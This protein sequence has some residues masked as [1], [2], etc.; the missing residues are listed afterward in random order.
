MYRWHY[1][2]KAVS[3]CSHQIFC[4]ASIYDIILMPEISKPSVHKSVYGGSSMQ[5]MHALILHLMRMAQSS[6]PI[7][8]GTVLQMDFWNVVLPSLTGVCW[9]WIECWYGLFNQ[10]P[11]IVKRLSFVLQ[12]QL[13][14][15]SFSWSWSCVCF[16]WA[17][18][19]HP[20]CTSNCTIWVTTELA[21]KLEYWL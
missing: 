1:S 7:R 18:I 4:V 20:S 3:I 5:P 12:I 16:K 13:C 19:T 15:A 2:C 10:Q 6:L 9:L 17:D 8:N 11:L 21:M 14:Y